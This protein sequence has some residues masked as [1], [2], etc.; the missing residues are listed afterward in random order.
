M[1]QKFLGTYFII[2]VKKKQIEARRVRDEARRVE[3]EVQRI[4]E[5][6]ELEYIEMTDIRLSDIRL[7][8]SDTSDTFTPVVSKKSKRKSRPKR[9]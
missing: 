4:E 8:D 6:E 5:S 7:S 1:M 3:D 9:K 2:Y